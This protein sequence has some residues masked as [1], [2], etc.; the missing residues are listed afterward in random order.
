[1]AL[2]PWTEADNVLVRSGSSQP[3][4]G[5]MEDPST[6]AK[7]EII[8]VRDPTDELAGPRGAPRTTCVLSEMPGAGNRD[9]SIE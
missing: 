4:V 5:V 2:T 6:R 1:M 9:H 8:L 3:L 7:R